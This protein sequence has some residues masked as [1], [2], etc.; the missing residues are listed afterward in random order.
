[1][2]LDLNS[3]R[4]STQEAGHSPY[5][6]GVIN[7]DARQIRPHV[8]PEDAVNEVLITIEQHRWRC[9][10]SSLLNSLPLAQ[11]SLEVFDQQLFTDGI[12]LGADQ[13]AGA[14]R[15]D[16]HSQ[17]PQAVA[18][19]ISTDPARNVHPLP[20]GLQHEVATGQ[21]QV[22]SEARTFGAGWLLHHLDQN[23]LAWLQQLGDAC[24][25]LFQPQRTEIGDMNKAVLFA[26]ADVDESSIDSRQNIL[27]RAEINIT[28]LVATLGDD[29]LVDP[30][31]G[32]HCCNAQLLRDDNVLGHKS[33]R[34]PHGTQ[35]PSATIRCA[36]GG[37]VEAGPSWPK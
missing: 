14:G 16:Q 9:A 8:I 29:E 2:G 32:Q 28:D 27:H 37:D 5:S 23:L 4:I 35:I 20:M 19:G 33:G 26:F 12:G 11:Q 6:V 34:S 15:L 25:A 31:I 3:A 22:S 10:F 18:L 21:G 24:R 17:G 36:A 13:Q 1:M 30:F 7:D